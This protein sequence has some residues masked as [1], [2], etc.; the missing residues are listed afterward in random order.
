MKPPIRLKNTA[1]LAIFLLTVRMTCASVAKS[2]R[3]LSFRRLDGLSQDQSPILGAGT[4]EMG[5]CLE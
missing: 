3:A 1:F 2:L 4:V 5:F